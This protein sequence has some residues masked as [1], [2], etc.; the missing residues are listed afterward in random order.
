MEGDADVI[1]RSSGR[2]V[3]SVE[4][5]DRLAFQ[6]RDVFVTGDDTNVR[7]YF[8][9]DQTAVTTDFRR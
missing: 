4:T 8:C 7:K 2:G 1:L 5:H 3:V 9:E 6:T